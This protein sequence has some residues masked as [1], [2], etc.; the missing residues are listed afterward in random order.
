MSVAEDTIID[1]VRAINTYKMLQQIEQNAAL[2]GV[3]TVK[4]INQMFTDDAATN[5]QYWLNA[6]VVKTQVNVLKEK[7]LVFMITLVGSLLFSTVL[8]YMVLQFPGHAWILGAVI[9][10]G[11]VAGVF[12]GCFAINEDTDIGGG[13]TI[14][15]EANR[16]PLEKSLEVSMPFIIFTAVLS[17]VAALAGL[18]IWMATR[19]ADATAAATA[20]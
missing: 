18:L 9:A 14:R 13:V 17:G 5:G 6:R 16:S 11:M 20:P 15:E 8:M 1:L 3:G 10:A 12:V 7:E 19:K 4:P 2:T